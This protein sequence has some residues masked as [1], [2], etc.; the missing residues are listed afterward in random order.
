MPDQPE[1]PIVTIAKEGTSD[2]EFIL[3]IN[4]I[5]TTIT[6]PNGG[7]F[8][9][10]GGMARPLPWIPIPI[11]ACFLKSF[12]SIGTDCTARF[13]RGETTIIP[14]SDDRNRSALTLAKA[15]GLKPVAVDNRVATD[16]KIILAKLSALGGLTLE[17]Q[18]ANVDAIIADPVAKIIDWQ[19]Q[20]LVNRPDILDKHA[21]AIVIG[22]QRAAAVT[23]NARVSARESGLILARL[24]SELPEESFMARGPRVLP[25]FAKA[26]DEH[27]LWEADRLLARLGALGPDA[28]PYLTNP[29]ATINSVTKPGVEGLCRVGAP[30]RAAAEPVL[31]DL[32]THPSLRERDDKLMAIYVAMRRIGITPPPLINDKRD[33]LV[34]WQEVW[35]GISP[36]SPSRV[37]SVMKEYKARS[38]A[39]NE[40]RIK[41]KSK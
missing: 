21:D 27:W 30:A 37:C 39:L 11:V 22:L 33:S 5:T 12:E 7:K 20:V 26:D 3:P 25:V 9:L 35:A 34:K 17:R 24:I 1:L 31:L 41:A 40:R 8:E 23:G 14:E 19:V 2:V 28:L 29:R 32:W 15:L 16:S 4:R 13:N 6:M 38:D 18:W 10:L 36:S